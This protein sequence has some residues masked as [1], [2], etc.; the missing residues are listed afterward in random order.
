MLK[1]QVVCWKIL[2]LIHS[3]ANFHGVNTLTRLMSGCQFVITDCGAVQHFYC[4][5]TIDVTS[6]V[7]VK[8]GKPTREREKPVLS[9]YCLCF[10]R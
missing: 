10:I 1:N 2:A 9:T 4:T 7:R 8:C 3:F 6:R 5:H